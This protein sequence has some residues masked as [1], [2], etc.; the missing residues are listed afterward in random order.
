MQQ[1]LFN[2]AVAAAGLPSVQ[3]LLQLACSCTCCCWKVRHGADQGGFVG[4]AVAAA[5]AVPVHQPRHSS[6]LCRCLWLHEHC[7]RCLQLAAAG[8]C[9][10][11]VDKNG[12]R[13]MLSA[14]PPQQQQLLLFL[15]L[16]AGT[17]ITAPEGS[18]SDDVQW[19]LCQRSHACTLACSC[20]SVQCT[21]MLWLVY[22]YGSCHFAQ[23]QEAARPC[24]VAGCFRGCS[25]ALHQQRQGCP[26][27]THSIC[28]CG[29]AV[30]HEWTA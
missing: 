25:G 14:L 9:P 4:G 13:M 24:V 12:A 19:V 27:P 2:K 8:L 26:S 11:C 6:S 1:N 10:K 7:W 22:S 21:I 5:S 18:E 3:L 20:A 17:A 30:I 23:Q 15:L 16:S 29:A 28:A